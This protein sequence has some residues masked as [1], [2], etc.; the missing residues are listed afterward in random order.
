[1]IKRS[2]ITLNHRF[3]DCFLF[4]LYLAEIY[5]IFSRLSNVKT[6]VLARVKVLAVH[7]PFCKFVSDISLY[8][9]KGRLG[10]R[11]R[12]RIKFVFECG[13]ATGSRMFLFQLAALLLP[14]VSW[15]AL[16][17]AFYDFTLWTKKRNKRQRREHLTIG[18]HPSLENAIAYK[19]SLITYIHKLHKCVCSIYML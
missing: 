12:S 1:M 16:V 3:L 9:G 2:I 11:L 7:A 10:T 14:P 8:A 6:I 4:S 19:N 15:K 5:K 18:W 13:R 17:L